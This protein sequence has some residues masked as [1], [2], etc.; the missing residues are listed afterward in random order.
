MLTLLLLAFLLA[1]FTI[2]KV[3]VDEVRDVLAKGLDGLPRVFCLGK[4]NPLD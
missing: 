1:L 2:L 3:F 4:A